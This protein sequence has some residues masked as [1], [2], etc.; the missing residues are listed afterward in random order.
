MSLEWDEV[1]G[2]LLRVIE[3]GHAPSV[4]RICIVRDLRGRVRMAMRKRPS[5]GTLDPLG[6]D[7]AVKSEL[8]AWF[9]EPTLWADAPSAE[10]R[11]LA[12][13]LLQQN[14]AWPQGWPRQ[15]DDGTG[16]FRP[17]T[18]RLW[19]G[20]ERVRAKQSWLAQGNS[21]PPW[22]LHEK[23]PAIVSFYSFKGG[24]GRTTTLG[25]VARLMAKEGRKVVVVDL[26]LEAP[27][28]GRFFDVNPDR[29]VLDL[30]VEHLATE[31]L[32][33]A[34]LDRHSQSIQFGNGEVVVFPV[35][36][37]GWSYIEKLGRLDFAPQLGLGAASP[38]ESALR[39]ILRAIR[40]RH[41]P[42][43]ILLDARAGL[44]DIGGLTLHALS[45][46]D[47]LVGRKGPATLDGFR[48]ALDALS[49]RRRR[50]DHRVLLVQTFVPLP[51]TGEESRAVQDDWCAK[52]W[53]CVGQTLDR[54][55]GVERPGVSDR[56][57]R[58]FPWPVP[59]LDSIARVDRIH[60]IENATL[61][62]EP[63]VT[64]R[65]RVHERCLRSMS[66]GDAAEGENDGG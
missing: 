59:A 6:L 16:S 58:H 29:G 9:T 11:R 46:L 44:H 49:R 5:A 47:V 3:A 22:P 21:E 17:I 24:V 33:R 53:D 4:D 57:A 14:A 55:E 15:W 64:I 8:G 63:F 1:L 39:E 43:Y 13:N 52:L 51:T 34:D 37:L 19:C 20:E 42:D 45:H 60:D 25:A 40:E 38:V 61:D 30:L 66:P 7:A 65:D 31:T 28:A 32:D 48:L 26:D 41:S 62:A 56:T 12:Q 36:Q 27:G 23:T 18:E 54:V 35:G 2:R 10:V 50:E